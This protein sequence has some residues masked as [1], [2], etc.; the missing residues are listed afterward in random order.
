MKKKLFLLPLVMFALAAC[1]GTT[2]GGGGGGGNNEPPAPV[3]KTVELNAG[4]VL[5]YDA[6]KKTNVNYG[7]SEAAV[8]VEGVKVD[9]V[10]IGCYANSTDDSGA[11]VYDTKGWFQMRNK[12]GVHSILNVEAPGAIKSVDIVLALRKSN[13]DATKPLWVKFGEEV[14]TQDFVKDTDKYTVAPTATDA[15]KVTLE[16]DVDDG[17]TYTMYIESVSVTYVA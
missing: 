2:E 3:E 11:E 14:K 17:Y 5:G 8:E 7:D 16:Y 9:W 13:Y 6:S 4:N 10:G 12:N 15:K 1:G